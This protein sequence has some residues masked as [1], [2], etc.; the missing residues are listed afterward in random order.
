MGKRQYQMNQRTSV[1]LNTLTLLGTLMLP[2]SFASAEESLQVGHETSINCWSYGTK[3]YAEK[4]LI[5]VEISKSESHVKIDANA[6]SAEVYVV[7][8]QAA[9]VCATRTPK[10]P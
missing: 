5:S 4:E 7:D 8:A 10:G 6:E 2:A 1:A 9:L 3:V